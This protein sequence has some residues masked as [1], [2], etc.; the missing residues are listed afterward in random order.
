MTHTA[1]PVPFILY[2]GEKKEIDGVAGYDEESAAATGLVVQEG[3][4]LMNMMMG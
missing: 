3:Y 4:R 2:S 1:D